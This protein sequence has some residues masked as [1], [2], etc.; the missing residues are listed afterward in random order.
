MQYSQPLGHQQFQSRQ[1]QPGHVQHS[2][3]QNQINQ[4]NQLRGHLGQFAGSANNALFNAAQSSPNSQ[5]VS[6]Y[7]TSVVHFLSPMWLFYKKNYIFVVLVF[8][9]LFNWL[10]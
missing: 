6:L 1:M 5:M 7:S 10:Q 8:S 3:G 4:G 9:Y 2:I